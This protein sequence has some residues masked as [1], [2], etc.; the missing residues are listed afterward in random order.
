MSPE[1]HSGN[2]VGPV[3]S[4]E[5]ASHEALFQGAEVFPGFHPGLI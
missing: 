1:F 2:H 3:F 4:P 5:R